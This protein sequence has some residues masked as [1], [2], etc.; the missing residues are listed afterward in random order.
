M[1]VSI[2]LA[3]FILIC[4]LFTYYI[5]IYIYIYIYIYKFLKND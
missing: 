4:T 2:I 1:Y 3:L 5:D